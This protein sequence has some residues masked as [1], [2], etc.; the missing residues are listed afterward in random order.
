MELE[1]TQTLGT[2]HNNHFSMVHTLAVYESTLISGGGDGLLKFWDM[3][4]RVCKGTLSA[5]SSTIWDLYVCKEWGCV[6]SASKDHTLRSWDVESMCSSGLVLRFDAEVCAVEP[7][8]KFLC[9][10]CSDGTVHIVT[11]QTLQRVYLF[12][13]WPSSR[14]VNN[15][16][17]DNNHLG[18]VYV[19]IDEVLSVV[20]VEERIVEAQINSD[21]ESPSFALTKV[22]GPKEEPQGIDCIVIIIFFFCVFNAFDSCFFLVFTDN[23]QI[24]SSFF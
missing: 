3:K 4:K 12:R 10:G 23:K 1:G 16:V 21:E 17:V 14:C 11:P 15:I 22:L 20:D 9:C 13:A 7:L 8:K 2:T 18:R 6:I 19:T 5:H 24:T